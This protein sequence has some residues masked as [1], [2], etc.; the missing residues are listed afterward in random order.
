MSVIE[1]IRAALWARDEAAPWGIPGRW[2]LAALGVAML[3]GA[4]AGYLLFTGPHMTQQ[5]HLRVFGAPMPRPAPGALPV[6][7]LG[8]EVPTAQEAAALSNPLP[9]TAQNR[10]R[11]ATYYAYYCAFCHGSKG[12]G[13]GPVG[14]SYVPKPS[15]LRSP[16]IQAYSD[17]ELLRSM[18][19]GTGHAP[20]LE[21]TVL[22]EHRWYLVHFVRA[23]TAAK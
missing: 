12:D 1:R 9:P 16:K 11:G 15:D 19:T 18:L 10:A 20:A 7:S 4:A 13:N 22:P 17:G 23:F 2:L 6:T 5:P 21:T 8:F 14:E 3:G